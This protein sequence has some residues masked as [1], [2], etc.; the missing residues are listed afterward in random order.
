MFNFLPTKQLLFVLVETDKLL[1]AEPN[2]S[3]LPREKR[4]LDHGGGITACSCLLCHWPVKI[5]NAIEATVEFQ[6]GK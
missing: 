6:I 3:C 1:P 2:P 5:W 4:A